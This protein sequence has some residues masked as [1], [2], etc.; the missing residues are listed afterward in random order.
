MNKSILFTLGILFLSAS[1]H[2][3]QANW[4]MCTSQRVALE[5]S[6]QE[7]I[8]ATIEGQKA[9]VADED[10]IPTLYK[11]KWSPRTKSLRLNYTGLSVALSGVPFYVKQ[12]FFAGNCKASENKF[13]AVFSGTAADKSI[14]HETVYCTMTHDVSAGTSCD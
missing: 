13:K 2:A 11:I 5:I 6:D 3:G 12:D 7:E 1:A 10:L 9:A 4:L 14:H 8:S